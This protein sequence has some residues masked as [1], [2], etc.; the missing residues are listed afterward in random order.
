[1]VTFHGYVS[2]KQ[3]VEKMVTWMAMMNNKNLGPGCFLT[4]GT[5]WFQPP[6]NIAG[7]V[8]SILMVWHLACYL[9]KWTFTCIAHQHVF[10]TMWNYWFYHFSIRRSLRT[11]M[12]SSQDPVRWLFGINLAQSQKAQFPAKHDWMITGHTKNQRFLPD[13]EK[14]W[15]TYWGLKQKIWRSLA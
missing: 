7:E 3:M 10:I 8:W 1:M 15:K 11:A 12:V 6:R 5:L 9:F 2:H 13:M 4:D 14:Q